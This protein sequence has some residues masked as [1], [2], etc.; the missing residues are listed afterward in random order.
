MRDVHYHTRVL[1]HVS[2][3]LCLHLSL[4]SSRPP[5]CRGSVLLSVSSIILST[6]VSHLHPLCHGPPP[7]VFSCQIPWFTCEVFLP[8][9]VPHS[10]LPPSHSYLI[11]MISASLSPS[12][13]SSLQR[14]LDN[15]CHSRRFNLYKTN[16]KGGGC[17]HPFMSL[18]HS[19][20]IPAVWIPPIRSSIL[21]FWD[22]SLPPPSSSKSPPPFCGTQKIFFCH[23]SCGYIS[24]WQLKYTALNSLYTIW[25]SVVEPTQIS[26]VNTDCSYMKHKAESQSV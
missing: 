18:C 24:S 5:H 21:A 3:S 8:P 16:R 17:I 6:F 22:P 25:G 7:P 23:M 4:S 14:L 19:L 1:L 13:L 15:R 10:F 2:H 11:L 26:S 20:F 12:F 9:A